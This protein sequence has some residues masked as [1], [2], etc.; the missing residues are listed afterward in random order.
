MDK[1]QF[2]RL[3]D[4]IMHF[5]TALNEFSKSR[6]GHIKREYPGEPHPQLNFNEQKKKH[7][8]GLMRVN[9]AGEIAAQALYKA[10]ALTA[11][12][13]KLKKTMKKSAEEEIDHLD[14]C[15]RRLDELDGHTSY[16]APIWYLG[17]FGIGVLAGCFG[18]EW[19]LGFI[20]ETEYQV[21][22][23]LDAHLEQLPEDDERSRAILEQMREDELH[24]ATVA[25]TSGA[26]NLP[27]GIKRLMTLASKIMTKTA[28]HI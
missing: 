20:A 2:N 28:Y 3:D 21:V 6:L 10:Q 15:E 11:T 17:S 24:H 16:L 5:D 14:W 9:H 13:D 23:H 26:K 27:E 19:N 1:R 8:S 25:E 7:V 22:R 4:V 12:D 18:D